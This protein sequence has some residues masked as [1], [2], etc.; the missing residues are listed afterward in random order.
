MTALGISKRLQ[1]RRLEGKR[2]FDG[3][4]LDIC[5]RL[6]PC[7][8]PKSCASFDTNLYARELIRDQDESTLSM[9][10]QHHSDAFGPCVRGVVQMSAAQVQFR[11]RHARTHV[12]TPGPPSSSLALVFPVMHRDCGIGGSGGPW[13]GPLLPRVGVGHVR[14]TEIRCNNLWVSLKSLVSALAQPPA[15][16]F[17]SRSS[18]DHRCP[19]VTVFGKGLIL[20]DYFRYICTWYYYY[21]RSRPHNHYLP[22]NSRSY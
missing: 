4:S 8:A 12:W 2:P 10:E 15:F 7:L 19:T 22:P 9:S 5:G 14:K 17:V 11:P 16:C 1:G 6:H 13:Q 3:N 21:P 20:L 18:V